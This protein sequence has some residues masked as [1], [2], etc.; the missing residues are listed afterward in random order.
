[1]VSG[2]LYA[3]GALLLAPI[4]KKV[5]VDSGAGLNTVRIEK[6]TLSL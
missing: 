4:G 3:P 5:W 6:K 1:M 2:Q